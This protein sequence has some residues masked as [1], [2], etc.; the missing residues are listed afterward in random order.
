LDLF[1]LFHHFH[2]H[3]RGFARFAASRAAAARKKTFPSHCL[4]CVC[5]YI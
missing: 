5:L 2:M 1:L 3:R 4:E